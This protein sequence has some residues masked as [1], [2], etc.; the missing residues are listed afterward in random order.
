MGSHPAMRI[1]NAGLSIQPH[2]SGPQNPAYPQ[3]DVIPPSASTY[4]G[5]NSPFTNYGDEAPL[6]GNATKQE[7]K[8]FRNSSLV[9]SLSRRLSRKDKQKAGTPPL[10]S[11]QIAGGQNQSGEQSAGRLINMISSA[12]QGPPNDRDA[13]YSMLNAMD[14]PDRPQTPFSFVGG[15]DENDAF[16]MVDLRE[17]GSLSSHESLKEEPEEE[18][19]VTKIDGNSS[20]IPQ[21]TIDVI[22]R[23]KS[24]GPTGVQ[25]S[26]P[27]DAQ[28]VPITRFK[29]LRSGV[30]RMNSNISRSTSLK[31]LGSLKTVHHN[32]YRDDMAIEGAMGEN[33]VAAF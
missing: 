2:M 27:D 1:H 22:P 29:S 3:I 32:W 8:L 6:V 25:L 30:S 7:I 33:A 24:A 31:R 20:A 15:K 16:E 12:M 13:Q 5:V 4:R 21:D 10:P 14:Q 26:V 23:A 19:T 11:Q 9:R 28:R 18:F 17:K